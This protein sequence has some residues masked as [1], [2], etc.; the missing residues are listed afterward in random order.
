[1][2]FAFIVL[3]FVAAVNAPRRRRALP[4]TDGRA[5]LLRLAAGGLVALAA[6]AGGVA[7]AEPFLDA[8]D[9]APE[10]FEIAAGLVAVL[11]GGWAL[12]FPEPWDQPG[13]PGWGMAL[14]PVAF[15]LLLSA[16]FAALVVSFGALE[17]AGT[18]IGGA[19]VGIATL[20]ASGLLRRTA[21]AVDTVLLG[22]ARLFGL[23]LVG[24]GV[25]LIVEGVR[26]V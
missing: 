22:L 12:A 17:P 23:G 9:V 16:E 11:G 2:S 25:Q 19:A 1:M 18:A 10:S 6:A 3:A 14:V 4:E 24:V 5:D 8:I 21:P 7:V 26:D 20:V 13:L 15:P